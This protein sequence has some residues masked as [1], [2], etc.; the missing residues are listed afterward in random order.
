MQRYAHWLR[1]S[2]ANDG[3]AVALAPE[4]GRPGE[5]SIQPDSQE[6]VDL[7]GD[8][9]DGRLNFDDE[10]GEDNQVVLTREA[11]S[12]A[13]HEV[14]Q[15]TRIAGRVASPATD[16]NVSVHAGS[17]D[18]LGSS[19]GLEPE[20]KRARI[21]ADATASEPSEPSRPSLLRRPRPSRSDVS[22]EP[23]GSPGLGT[24][25]SRGHKREPE[26]ELVDLESEIRETGPVIPRRLD[27]LHW[28][29]DFSENVV[30]SELVTRPEV[31]D[32]EVNS[33]RYSSQRSQESS[34]KVQLG[35]SHVLLW[36]PDGGVDDSTLEELPSDL[37][38]LGM[39]EEISNLERCK[40]GK[41]I[42]QAEVDRL[43]TLHGNLRVIPSRWVCA[44]K[45]PTKVRS[46]IVAKDL[47]N[48]G[49]ARKMG[50]SSPTPS[51]VAL[52]VVIIMM[53]TRDMLGCGAD[54]GHA[55]MHSP[56]EA[57][58]PVILKLPLSV[59]LLN[60]LPAYF[61]LYC[62]LNGLREASLAWLRLLTS[63]IKPLGLYC[64]DREP[65]LFT[66]IV[67]T[68]AR[69][70]RALV[71]AYVDD[72][73]VVSE[74]EEL[75]KAIL[76]AIG[77]RVTVKVTGHIYPSYAGGGTLSFLGRILRRWPQSQTVELSIDKEYLNPCFES[78]GITKGSNAVPDIA[79][80]LEKPGPE[81]SPEAYSKFRR[82]L[83]R[84]LWYAQTR[85][86]LKLMLTLI[87]T[88]QSKPTS[89]TEQALRAILRFLICDRNVVH[90]VPSSGLSEDFLQCSWSDL[91]KRV[92]VFTDASYAPYRFLDR[93]GI[94][95]G[96]ICFA[97]SLVRLVAKTQGVVCLSSCEAELHALQYMSQECIAFMF[98][99]E[100]VLSSFGEKVG[101]YGVK[102]NAHDRKEGDPSS[103]GLSEILTDSQS[104][105]A[106]LHGEDLPRRSR[107]IEIR[108]AWLREHLRSGK[109]KLQW[110][111]GTENPADLMT[112][113]L[114]TRLYT[115]HR[116]RV[117]LVMQEGPVATL[118]ELSQFHSR[119][120]GELSELH[121]YAGSDEK[122][123]IAVV[124]M[125]C[126]EHS[127][128]SQACSRRGVPYIGI[129]G[130]GET[131]RVFKQARSLV[132]EWMNRGLWVHIHV[133][134][135]CSSGS[136]LKR[137]T[138]TTTEADFSWEGLS[139]YALKYLNLGCAGS[140]ELPLHND[141]WK[142]F[143]TQKLLREACLEFQAVVCLCATGV[144]SK[145][146]APVGK[147]LRFQCSHAA[148]ARVLHDLFGE[149]T[150]QSHANFNDV[151]FHATGTY[152][153]ALADGI[154]K[155]AAA[156]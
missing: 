128:L 35:G 50:F 46:R 156:V 137:F 37:V 110:I 126:P 1:E 106:L 78:Y 107:H 55:F 34:E 121:I 144:R 135:P 77:K 41:V 8:E 119:G 18:A 86:D 20:T 28:S 6:D 90:Q 154:V 93:R 102:V 88:Q 53:A 97:G 143:G 9:F 31:V 3:A 120:D 10:P 134:T 22:M 83:G 113:C 51:L 99:V 91:L 111:S 104:A 63:L 138:R 7:P 44:R 105:I 89:S 40:T 16:G 133:S 130:G 27:G 146:G 58:T 142:R 87:A 4:V 79:S 24:E 43:R 132:E 129:V 75:D 57:K 101:P 17:G 69:T 21:A 13:S 108:I 15:P 155:A 64:D 29:S 123:L 140:F 125:C 141:I 33:I 38:F 32:D 59:S 74:H 65:C 52:M 23:A 14:R 124:E 85:Q 73:L 5:Q 82:T 153:Q 84:L 71:V 45:N 49:S 2:V 66:G 114:G 139:K 36:R 67:K 98:I 95:G 145:S 81:L 70:G 39:K 131:Q 60:G 117:G 72:L 152:S 96:A 127:T 26:V 12:R 54:I 11:P 42:S 122:A 48:N 19:G 62:A 100:R 61:Y 94:T 151:D 116:E 30:L 92:H 115:I 68:K 147:K 103:E 109:S 118:F 80:V 149:C 150:C 112:K 148:F 76:A 136:P 56:L 25:T 47:A